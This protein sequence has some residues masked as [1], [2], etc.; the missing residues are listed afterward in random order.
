MSNSRRTS[1]SGSAAVGSSMIRT[2]ASCDSAV[3]ISTRWRLATE[4]VADR[5]VDVEIVACRAGRGAR[6]RRWRIAAPVER[7]AAACAARG[8][9]RCSRRPSAPGTAAVPGRRRRCRPP[10]PRAGRRSATVC[11]V[12]GDRCRRRAGATPDMILISVDLPAPFSPSSAWTSPGRTSKLTPRSTATGPNDFSIPSSAT[13][14][15]PGTPATD[16][17]GM[18]PRRRRS[19]PTDLLRRHSRR[20]RAETQRGCAAAFAENAGGGAGAAQA[21]TAWA[22]AR[23]RIACGMRSIGSSSSTPPMRLASAGMP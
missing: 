6:A 4:S 20:R 19:G 9:G 5:R 16:D 1:A 12:D 21:R 13:I 15:E 17:G 23:R 11:A 14:G 18:S 8:R 3:A 2:R 22:W 10:A 7:A